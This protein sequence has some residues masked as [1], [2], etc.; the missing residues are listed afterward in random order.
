MVERLILF[1][2]PGAGRYR[3]GGVA[4]LRSDASAR[5]IFANREGALRESCMKFP[6][7]VAQRALLIGI[8]AEIAVEGADV[9]DQRLGVIVVLAA[10]RVACRTRR[11]GRAGRRLRGA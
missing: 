6:R 2:V 4:F 3:R 7:P 9:G 8:P 1:R 5:A 11:I 10:M